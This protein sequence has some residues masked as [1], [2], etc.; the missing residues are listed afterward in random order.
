[1]SYFRSMTIAFGRNVTEDGGDFHT[2]S[3]DSD[4][5]YDILESVIDTFLNASYDVLS[6]VI[7]GYDF[8]EDMWEHIGYASNIP[9]VFQALCQ[10]AYSADDICA[11]LL[12]NDAADADQWEDGI[13]FSV[14]SYEEF[15]KEYAEI[16][17]RVYSESG[18]PFGQCTYVE[19]PA[20]PDYLVIDWEE[21]AEA[22]AAADS[23]SLVW[24]NDY[25]YYFG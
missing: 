18:K 2:I 10:D 6:V 16:F 13:R 17:N 23:A 4:H 22:I 25:L 21:S 3:V 19:A 24:F 15:V 5:D 14:G 20:F 12:E 7:D 8:E 11:F 1:M 9:G